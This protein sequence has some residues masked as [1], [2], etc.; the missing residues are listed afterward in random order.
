MKRVIVL[1]DGQN[2][3][4]SLREMNILEKQIKWDEFFKH[5]TLE[6]EE[7]IRVYWFR[8]QKILDTYYTN[9]TIKSHIV[10]K[11]HKTHF[12]N[13]KNNIEAVPEAI[14]QE[15]ELEAKKV[16]EWIREEKNKF[17]QIEYNYDNI[18]LEFQDIEIVKS[19]VVKINPFEQRYQCEKGVDI[20]LAVKMMALSVDKACDKIILVSGD[21]DYAEAIKYVKNKMTKIH[22]VKIHQGQP[23]KNKSVSRELAVL[24][25][26]IIDIYESDL[27]ARFNKANN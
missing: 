6:N 15:I 7:L 12:Q 18:A 24:A 9:W 2:L 23:P 26:N 17:A 27:K 19:G 21:Y 5:L 11:K 3:F 22:I 14:K 10:L 16:T 20:A 13:Y 4:Y 8:P 1:I 25:D